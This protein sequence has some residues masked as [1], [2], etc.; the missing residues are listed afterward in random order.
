MHA[1][2]IVRYNRDIQD[3]NNPQ[4]NSLSSLYY[5]LATIKLK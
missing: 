1:D 5:L 3:K 2:D 4:L